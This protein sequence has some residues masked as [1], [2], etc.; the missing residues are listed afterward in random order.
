LPGFYFDPE[1][2]RYFPISSRAAESRPPPPAPT[3]QLPPPSNNSDRPT[4]ATRSKRI[5]W[6]TGPSFAARTRVFNS[7][8]HAR[9]EATSQSQNA[10]WPVPLGTTVSAFATTPWPSD[11][12]VRQFI[13]D[14]NGCLYDR[15]YH[16]EWDEWG[17]W[18][19][20]LC[21]ARGSYVSA[22]LAT[23]DHVVS[24]CFGS[25]TKLAIQRSGVPDRTTLLNFP[26]ISDVRAASIQRGALALGSGSR[27]F[28]VPD[29]D[30]H[31]S[32]RV[33][34]TG[35]DVFSIAQHESLIYTGVRSGTVLR[36]DSRTKTD[37]T[38]HAQVIC[39][40]V[41]G[42]GS[43]PQAHAPLSSASFVRPL[44]DGA[45]IVVGF[46]DGRLA[47]YDLRFLRRSA[48]P[49]VV[50]ASLPPGP[51]TSPPPL[52]LG[53]SLDPA[54]RFVFSARRDGFLRGWA[55]HNGRPL[56]PPDTNTGDGLFTT[57]FASPPTALC[58][59]EEG[60]SVA[61][62]AAGDDQVSRWTLCV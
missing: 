2:N 30:V 49:T 48:P 19:L 18:T 60:G 52:P 36:F 34:A 44:S 1:R 51:S 55:L 28:L 33:I 43:D 17:D 12:A 50:Y 11:S 46:M 41:L 31:H 42:W 5:L 22:I 62:W 47:S 3:P 13:G 7:L 20:D 23:P 61:L 9:L 16:S 26:A 53:V 4:R 57:C 39:D 29:L 27:G 35:S 37:R 58:V 45:S 15:R 32:V 10:T 25:S 24:V 56:E 54:E 14:N 8:L 59:I 21:L 6:T 38:A 40:S